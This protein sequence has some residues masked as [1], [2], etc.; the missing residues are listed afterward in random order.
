MTC[1]ALTAPCWGPVHKLTAFP[2]HPDE[3][4]NTDV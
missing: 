4:F 3:G 1:L 2:K